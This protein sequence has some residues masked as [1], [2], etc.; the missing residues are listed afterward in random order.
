MVNVGYILKV[1]M[2]RFADETD[3]MWKIKE[4]VK[5]EI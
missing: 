3:K 2:K 4:K 1:E 5:V